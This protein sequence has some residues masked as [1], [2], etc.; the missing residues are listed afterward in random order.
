MTKTTRNRLLILATSSVIAIGGISAAFYLHA[1]QGERK[2]QEARTEGL[3]LFAQQKYPAA[4]GKLS[5][6]ISHHQTDREA[7]FAYA[8]S[9]AL[10]QEPDGRHVIEGLQLLRRYL[11]LAP[12]DA[13]ARELLLDLY[14]RAGYANE[15]VELSDRVLASRPD[16]LGALRARYIG[17]GRLR[18]FGEAITAT[19]N[20]I[21]RSPAD[22]G[23]HQFKLALLDVSK[24]SPETILQHSKETSRTLGE[25]DPRA[26]LVRA[27]ALATTQQVP[28]AIESLRRGTE[29]A[30]SNPSTR[31]APSDTRVPAF[32]LDADFVTRAA[33]LFDGLELFAEGQRLVERAADARAT[34]SD[35]AYTVATRLWAANR[36]D[37]VVERTA[38]LDATAPTRLLA[39]RALSLLQLGQAEAAKPIVA[40][41][42]DRQ[43]DPLAVGWVTALRAAFLKPDASL[44]DRRTDYLSARSSLLA[45]RDPV[46]E[47]V[48]Y[49]LLAGVE[50]DLGETELAISYW[51]AAHTRLP[52]W[53]TPVQ[54]LIRAYLDVDATT[55]ARQLGRELYLRSPTVSNVAL[56]T[57]AWARYLARYPDPADA[58]RLLSFVSDAY[59][60]APD[61]LRLAPARVLAHLAR[62]DRSFAISIL[63]P[64]LQDPK[65][66]APVLTQL[67]QIASTAS[68]GLD[69]EV[70]AALDRA[71]TQPANPVAAG[72]QG[73]S[74][75]TTLSADYV[76][77]AAL[78]QAATGQADK[79]LDQLKQAVS[80]HANS[81]DAPRWEL[82]LAQYLDAT[83]D[84]AALDSYR[85]LAKRYPDALFVHQAVLSSR[86]GWEDRTLLAASIDRLKALTGPDAVTW[87]LARARLLLLGDE[88]TGQVSDRDSAEAVSILS[89]IVSVAPRMVAPRLLL[90]KALQSVNVASSLEQLSVAADLDRQ[91]PFIAYELARKLIARGRPSDA[92]QTVLRIVQSPS[93]TLGQRVRFA[94]LLAELGD[95]ASAIEVLSRPVNA[96]PIGPSTAD[97]YTAQNLAERDAVLARLL[98]SDR[99]RQKE[100]GALY[101]K[102]LA[103]S[104]PT[105]TSAAGSVP[106][107][108]LAVDAAEFFARTQ[109]LT[110]ARK[111]LEDAV[112]DAPPDVADTARARLEENFGDRQLAVTL[113]RQVVD[114][115]RSTRG[116][117]HQAHA[118]TRDADPSRTIAS[119]YVNLAM[120]QLRLGQY[121]QA[122]QT[123]S[124]GIAVA[125]ADPALTTLAR[126]GEIVSLVP[127]RSDLQ[128]LVALIARDPLDPAARETLAVIRNA[129]SVT[130]DTS[131]TPP[132]KPAP[133]TRRPSY[134]LAEDRTIDALRTVVTK[135]PR[136]L[137]AHAALIDSLLAAGRKREAGEAAGRLF[138]GVLPNDPVAAQVAAAGYLGA[139]DPQ[140]ALG[141]ASKWRQ[142][143][144][145]D[146]TPADLA[147]A[148]AYLSTGD[149]DRALNQIQPYLESTSASANS[150]PLNM[151]FLRCRA[152]LALGRL[153]EAHAAVLQIWNS[154]ERVRPMLL[155]ELVSSLDDASA[156]SSQSASTAL[157]IIQRLASIPRLSPSDHYI[158]ARAYYQL[159]SR[160]RSPD[161]LK[162]ASDQLALVGS[163]TN[164]TPIHILSAQI[165]DALGDRS[166]AEQHYRAALALSPDSSVIANN[167][168]DL[169]VRSNTPSAAQE[170]LALARSA[171]QKNPGLSQFHDTLARVYVKLGQ[172]DAALDSFATALRLAPDR[173]DTLVSYASLL[174]TAGRSRDA[175]DALR[176]IDALLPS[177]DAST[178]AEVREQVQALR[179]SVRKASL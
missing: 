120:L 12:D 51:S 129:I 57:E 88:K 170:A 33:D 90:A 141:V 32:T 35:L 81:P 139:G 106:D 148:N 52:Q 36:M 38:S 58:D 105:G 111:I 162:L 100:A 113:L 167:L 177:A 74:P 69:S 133:T 18:R 15:A 26:L 98:A 31:P 179:E 107:I 91:S 103:R 20:F 144:P 17:L 70:Q 130:P 39:L 40:T 160:S 28:A 169:L 159:G 173:L 89:S 59:S 115:A 14:T 9:R 54:L 164:S 79:A 49:H 171:T 137:P 50:R 5:S 83:N 128:F 37:A 138:F 42:A 102:L 97:E 2:L 75:S 22:L 86:A 127:D 135:Y 56:A 161:T 76:L 153:D 140:A 112:K 66:P 119:P 82:L 150:V 125:P 156:S 96:A 109:N 46:A 121:I 10:T 122:T 163:N 123:I 118:A 29:L 108:S 19:D 78:R 8:K 85:N 47:A 62:G 21:T 1:R 147:L 166:A 71:N 13:E 25:E 149:P 101:E 143:T 77:R 165:A 151:T 178:S 124:E 68:L 67:A 174:S 4:L 168:A 116:S 99:R 60:Q 30:L 131:P 44:L 65:T 172:T 7:L 43:S 16:D 45:A 158:L 24:A 72:G 80:Q 34:D 155:N 92:R 110:R 87:R 53:T 27:M 94:R 48:L 145:D 11:D 104:A 41:L 95:S 132:E 136:F 23:A 6:Y 93:L 114:R 117:S 176:R 175:A 73:T 64:L 84:T 142:L 152:L 134:S 55:E 3:E 146:P 126:V 154:A 157:L 61:D 63:R